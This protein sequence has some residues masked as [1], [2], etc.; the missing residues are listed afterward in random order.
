M[1]C[2]LT[3][4]QGTAPPAISGILISGSKT[5]FWLRWTTCFQKIDGTWLIAHEQLSVPIDPASGKAL[6][7]LKP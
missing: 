3:S 1:F 5:G 2:T 4:G 6:L 7:D